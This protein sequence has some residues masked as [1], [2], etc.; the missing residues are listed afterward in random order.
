MR[1]NVTIRHR[2]VDTNYMYY[3]DTIFTEEDLLE[4]AKRKI[5]EEYDSMEA[6]SVEV[7]AIEL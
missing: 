4:W 7:N 3:V 5:A 6:V 1:L 2:F